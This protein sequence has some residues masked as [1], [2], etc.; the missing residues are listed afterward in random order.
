MSMELAVN[1]LVAG[2]L[3]AAIVWAVILDRRLRDLRSGR[4]G[5]KQAV[6][7]LA[8]AAARAET[9][10]AALR[11]AAERSGAELA[12]QQSKARAAADELTLLVGAAEGLADRLTARAAAPRAATARPVEA[13]RPAAPLRELRGAR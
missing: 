1:L 5:V 11:E 4:D 12:T 9:A 3:A 7:D 2:L 8:G 10:V 6:M 13:L